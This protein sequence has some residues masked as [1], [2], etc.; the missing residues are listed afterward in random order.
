LEDATD[1]LDAHLKQGVLKERQYHKLYQRNT[2]KNLNDEAYIN[3]TARSLI[4][5][6]SQPP[7]TLLEAALQV[8]EDL[9]VKIEEFKDLK[10]GYDKQKYRNRYG[11]DQDELKRIQHNRKQK[12]FDKGRRNSFNEKVLAQGK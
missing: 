8:A 10:D 5:E 12:V 6:A 9:K 7:T 11:Q 3:R 4:S 1:A 2:K